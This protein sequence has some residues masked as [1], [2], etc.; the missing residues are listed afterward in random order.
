MHILSCNSDSALITGSSNTI[1]ILMN[2]KLHATKMH[3]RICSHNLLSK[4]YKTS[5]KNFMSHRNR[6]KKKNNYFFNSLKNYMFAH[7][8]LQT[9]SLIIKGYFLKW[10]DIV[11]CHYINLIFFFNLYLFAL[12]LLVSE[13]AWRF[14]IS[15]VY[16]PSSLTEMGSFVTFDTTWPADLPID[17]WRGVMITNQR[18]RE[19]SSRVERDAK[20]KKRLASTC[21]SLV[22]ARRWYK[23]VPGSVS[24]RFVACNT[25]GSA[26]SSGKLV[27]ATPLSTIM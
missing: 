25:K 1:T 4:Y 21:D 16:F 13:K 18:E 24:V 7:L 26:W 12:R 15:E 23:G 3:V 22:R 8:C 9:V 10:K 20:R 2:N 6:G 5:A 17:D 27:A 19:H 14:F 11:D